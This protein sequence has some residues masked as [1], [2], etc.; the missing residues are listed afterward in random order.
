M[1]PPPVVEAAV[2]EPDWFAY[3]AGQDHSMY[4]TRGTMRVLSVLA[5]AW[6][7]DGRDAW[8]VANVSDQRQVARV[9]DRPVDLPARTIKL[10]EP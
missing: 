7:L 8:L 5:R 4:E 9:D 1:L 2:I 3:N 10:I 6:R